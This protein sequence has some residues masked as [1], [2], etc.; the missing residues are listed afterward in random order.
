MSVVYSAGLDKE[1]KTLFL[2]VFSF[3]FR[4]QFLQ[5]ID[6]RCRHFREGRLL[7]R[8]P[9]FVIGQVRRGEKTESFAEGLNCEGDG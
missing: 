5:E 1:K 4:L 3:L 6:G 7:R 2:A 9:L 8:I